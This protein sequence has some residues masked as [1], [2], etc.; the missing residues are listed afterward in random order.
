MCSH[1]I[2][3]ANGGFGLIQGSTRQCLPCQDGRRMSCVGLQQ[4]R[5]V[6]F[7]AV[8]RRIDDP[9]LCEPLVE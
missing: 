5:Q 7:G 8:R 4:L 2:L 6:E 3:A 1:K 9:A